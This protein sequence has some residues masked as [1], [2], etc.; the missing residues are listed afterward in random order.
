MPPQKSADTRA[1]KD[2]R[3]LRF[4]SPDQAL[5]EMDRL[6]A[7]ER[8]GTLRT[9]GNWSLGQSL[10]HLAWWI[11]GPF[12]GYPGLHK[13]PAIIRWI[14]TLSKKKYI[15]KQLP[16]GARI[17]GIPGGTLGI[18]PL[19]T[20]EGLARVRAAWARLQRDTPSHPT[21]IFGTL[22]HDE[23]IAINLRHAELHLGFFHAI[24]ARETPAY[25]R[26]CP[27]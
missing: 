19:T 21:P 14:L 23:W 9:S 24:P 16:A 5:A 27:P 6:V 25:H 15:W 3:A 18:D 1:V 20:D 12:D 2:R 11:N 13:A 8:A 4:E 17:P 22:T 26:Q 7:A 10:G